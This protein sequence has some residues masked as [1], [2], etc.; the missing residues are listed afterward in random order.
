MCGVRVF[1][2]RMTHSMIISV[3][4]PLAFVGLRPILNL[5][6]IGRLKELA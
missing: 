6:F 2:A 1:T 4:S 5:R 3:F